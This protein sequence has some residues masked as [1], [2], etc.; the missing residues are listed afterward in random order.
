[1]TRP[2]GD[3]ERR[4]SAI[5]AC[6]DSAVQGDMRQSI[7]TG[8][9]VDLGTQYAPSLREPYRPVVGYPH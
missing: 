2:C 5:G 6:Q 3:S 1:M 4:E 8:T 9:V 7:L